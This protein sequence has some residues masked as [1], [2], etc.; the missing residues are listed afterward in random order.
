M[1]LQEPFAA[2]EVRL[3]GQDLELVFAA[4]DGAKAVLNECVVVGGHDLA[5]QVP[6]V[7]RFNTV[8]PKS[9]QT[10]LPQ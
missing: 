10:N 2:A 4:G 3:V 8:D 5:P 7:P 1:H 9:G 6:R